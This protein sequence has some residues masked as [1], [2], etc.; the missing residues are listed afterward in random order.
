MPRICAPA[1]VGGAIPADQLE[2][3]DADVLAGSTYWYELVA[4]DGDGNRSD[5][6]DRVIVTVGAPEL[7]VPPKPAALFRARPFP[8]VALSLRSIPPKLVAVVEERDA[9]GKWLEVAGPV[10]AAG[11]VNLT[12]LPQGAQSIDYRVVFLA[13]NGARGQPSEPVTVQVGR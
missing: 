3:S 4:I 13:A 8:Y 6:S 7:P 12:D 9:S 11:T 10:A 5:P 1:V 2:V